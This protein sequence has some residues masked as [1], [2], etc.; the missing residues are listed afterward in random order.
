MGN[1]SGIEIKFN[2]LPKLSPQLQQGARNE[3]ARAA[4]ALEAQEKAKIT[5]M[6]AIDSGFMLGSVQAQPD[7]D[8]AWTVANGAEY[9]PH[10]NYGTVKMPPRNFVESSV[11]VIDPQFHANMGKIVKG[12]GN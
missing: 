3:V 6:G 2:K 11:A 4:H 7:G 8:M 1:S 5:E 9:S 12:L 10:V